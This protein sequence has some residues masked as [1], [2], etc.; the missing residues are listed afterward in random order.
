MSDEELSLA[1]DEYT[2]ESVTAYAEDAAINSVEL[3]LPEERVRI[4][5]LLE[6]FPKQL[7]TKVEKLIGALGTLWRQD[8]EERVVVFATYLGSVEML[9]EEIEKA[10]P[11]QGV[12]VLKGGDHGSKLAAEKRFK[13]A[14][15]PKV[16]ICTAAGRE[17]I[18][19]QHARVLFNFDLPWNPMDLEQ[20]IGRIHRYGQRHTAQVYNL[21]LSD[22]IEGKIFL[23]LDDKLKE[24]AKALGKMDDHGEVAEDLRSQILGQLS[25]RL[26]YESLYTQAISD[27]ELKR[28]KLELE[29]ALTNAAEARQVVFELFQDL[30][31]FSLDDYRQFSDTTEGMGKIVR[32]L[33]AALEDD[34]KKLTPDGENDLIV[35]DGGTGQPEAR[36]TTVRDQSLTRPDVELLGLDHPL[37][38]EYLTGYR[39]LPAQEI[40][41]RVVAS[42]HRTGVLSVWHVTTQGD[43]GE[44]QTT[45]LPLAV[46]FKGQR[47]PSWE[48]QADSLFHR[49]PAT[50][51]SPARSDLLV[52]ALE[53]MIQRELLHRGVIG[54][55]RGDDAR[56][57]G[58]VE[59][60]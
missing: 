1:S 32:F 40:G 38:V 26:N 25:E 57:I 24:I 60:V 49:P 27:P 34:G 30:E 11:G 15:G 31:R 2:S 35:S 51:E 4:R 14:G 50:D 47:I 21:V 55:R 56:L 53:P 9:G 18:N 46:D 22:T 6:K 28:T 7:E 8:A 3:A 23:L 10:Y 42:D 54:E 29:A 5:E 39:A 43:R 33:R 45:I 36:L 13:Q 59:V 12:V 37:V 44:V 20:R 52:T 41:V 19:L 16:M 58:W 17:G 48:R